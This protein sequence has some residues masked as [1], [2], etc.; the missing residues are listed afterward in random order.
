MDREL[1]VLVGGAAFADVKVIRLGYNAGFGAANN[2][3]IKQASGEVGLFD[4]QFFMYS[5]ETDWC[6]RFW[7]GGWRV[8]FTPAA[9]VVHLNGGSGKQQADRVFHEFQ[10]SAE[11]YVRKHHGWLGL[12]AFRACMVGGACLRIGL[13]GVGSILPRQRSV[14]RRRVKEWTRILGWNLGVRR[15]GLQHS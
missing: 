15:R 13:F 12:M 10:R 9:E 7:R 4:E 2:W 14:S 6:R 5:E 8:A 11:R 3:A 1:I